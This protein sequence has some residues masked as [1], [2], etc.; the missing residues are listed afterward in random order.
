MKYPCLLFSKEQK[1]S[2]K[3]YIAMCEK[4]KEI[5]QR[6]RLAEGDCFYHPEVGV[7]EVLQIRG[8]RI[9]ATTEREVECLTDECTWLPS[10]EEL[11]KMDD[12]LDS[13][14]LKMFLEDVTGAYGYFPRAGIYFRTPE[15]QWLAYFMREIHSKIWDRINKEWIKVK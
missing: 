4:A 2:Y 10:K 15:S 9:T 3:R 14:G 13:D 11:E 12:N 7:N 6:H 8:D 5:Q 1:G